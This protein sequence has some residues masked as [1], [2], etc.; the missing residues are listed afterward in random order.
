MSQR[1]GTSDSIEMGIG[2]D[3]VT[4]QATTGKYLGH[5]IGRYYDQGLTSTSSSDDDDITSQTAKIRI[6]GSL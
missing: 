3:T 4:F 1:F 2:M 5:D 6:N